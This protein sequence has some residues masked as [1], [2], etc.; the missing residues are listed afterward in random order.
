MYTPKRSNFKDKTA[1][2]PRTAYASP[3]SD[4]LGNKSMAKG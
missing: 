4:D 1:K 3:F 2:T